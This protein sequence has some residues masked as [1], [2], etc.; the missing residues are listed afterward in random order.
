MGP[1]NPH[2]PKPRKYRRNDGYVGRSS[3]G[4]G[5]GTNG[6]VRKCHGRCPAA[7]GVVGR[8]HRGKTH[9]M[10]RPEDLARHLEAG[11]RDEE[12]AR[13]AA[14]ALEQSD[15]DVSVTV[16]AAADRRRVAKAEMRDEVESMVAGPGNVG[17]FTKGM[18]KGIA[19]WVPIAIGAGIVAGLLLG[20]VVSAAFDVPLPFGLL[21]GAAIGAAAGG[22]VGVH[23]KDP[24][25]LRR[26]EA[27]LTRLGAMR[28]D[29]IGDGG[30]IG[31]SSEEKRRPIRG[32]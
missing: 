24:D 12:S 1:P 8:T 28:T 2:V 17:P 29:F 18:T 19:A 11:F 10:E 4:S 3:T 6:T 13:R 27:E 26:A 30:P 9:R 31:P 5:R 23:S 22:A 21:A 32:D 14:R 20:W 7:R 15:L 16:D 25:E